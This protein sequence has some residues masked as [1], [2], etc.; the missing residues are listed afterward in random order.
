MNAPH[1][2]SFEAVE[3]A[4]QSVALTTVTFLDIYVYVG[5]VLGHLRVT[6]FS[7]LILSFVDAVFL[8]IIAY[9]L[10]FS[11]FFIILTAHPLIIFMTI[12]HAPYLSS[13]YLSADHGGTSNLVPY[14]EC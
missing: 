1:K 14:W 3:I 12:C 6:A 5:A 2:Y 11:L 4:L 10:L 9:L 7:P 13:L 8:I